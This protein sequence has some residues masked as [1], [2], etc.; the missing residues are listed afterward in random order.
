MTIYESLKNKDIDE[1]VEWIAENFYF[2]GAPWDKY[3]DENYCQKC[4]AVIACVT[5]Y[6][7]DEHKFAYCEINHNCR[8]FKEMKDTPDDKMLVKMWLESEC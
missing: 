8:F 3:W 5:E 7:E 1:L 6:G 2:G 4:E